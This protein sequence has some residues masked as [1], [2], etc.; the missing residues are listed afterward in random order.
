MKNGMTLLERQVRLSS[1]AL[2]CVIPIFELFP[3]SRSDKSRD[4][5]GICSKFHFRILL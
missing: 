5:K 3:F 4:S 1:S 2:V